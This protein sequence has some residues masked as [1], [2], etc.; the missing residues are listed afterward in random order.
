MPHHHRNLLTVIISSPPSPSPHRT[1]HRGSAAHRIV[2]ANR[3]T[4][5]GACGFLK[6]HDKGAFGSGFSTKGAFGY[7][8]RTKGAFGS[9]FSTKGAF[10]SGFRTKDAFGSRLSTIR[11]APR[12]AFGLTEAP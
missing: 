5:A 9:G 8:F 1:T 11:I 10:G 3:N 4:T 6:H 7:G 12:G 2:T